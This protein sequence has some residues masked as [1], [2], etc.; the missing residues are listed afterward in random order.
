MLVAAG[1]SLSA[2]DHKGFTPRMLA[3]QVE[4]HELAA[5]LES[6]FLT[7]NLTSIF[8]TYTNTQIYSIVTLFI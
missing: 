6:E 7:G 3:L 2:T 5:Y 1:A 4:D 8:I